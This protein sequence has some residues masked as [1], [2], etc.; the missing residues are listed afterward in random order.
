MPT[1]LP[2]FYIIPNMV[3]LT[4]CLR[5][6]FSVKSRFQRASSTRV[7]IM[8]GQAG[9]A[10][11]ESRLKLCKPT[12]PRIFPVSGPTWASAAR[13]HRAAGRLHA[14][15]SRS[16]H[17]CKSN[18]LKPNALFLCASTLHSIT[19]LRDSSSSAICLTLEQSSC[20]Y[21]LVAI[22]STSGN[23]TLYILSS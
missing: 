11:C 18:L 16:P 12:R 3:E 15:V 6:N 20:L 1:C 4:L 10:H 9:L 5:A 14:L 22:P 2:Q 8:L 17:L 13:E 23:Q 21:V 7:G 19:P